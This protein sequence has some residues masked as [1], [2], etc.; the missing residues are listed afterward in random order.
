MTQQRPNYTVLEGMT[1]FT[2]GVL[3]T[4]APLPIHPYTGDLMVSQNLPPYAEL[5][6]LGQGRTVQTA[7]LFAPLV[8]I[9][10]TTAALELFNN[11]LDQVLLISDLFA[12]EV[13]ATAV[14]DTKA[15]YAMITTKKVVPTLT[16]LVLHSMSGKA[17]ITPTAVSDIV[18]GVGTTV[19]ANGWRPW[20]NAIPWAVKAAT[21]GYSWSVPTEGRLMVPPSCSLCLHV[22][23]SLATASSFQVGCSFD[24]A[25]MKVVP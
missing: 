6:R 1:R 16:A 13:L 17:S 18:T 25:T 24:I 7:T 14:A 20:G 2:P 21:P 22:M 5:T 8:A 23:G 9:P 3:S 15:I 12:S 4:P 10:T 11:T 19:I